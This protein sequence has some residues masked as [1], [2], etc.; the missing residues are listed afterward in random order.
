MRIAALLL[1][2]LLPL[3]LSANEVLFRFVQITDIHIGWEKDRGF[4]RSIP[5]QVNA[6]TGIEFVVLTGDIFD[7]PLDKADQSLIDEYKKFASAFKV[8]FYAIPGNHDISRGKKAAPEAARRFQELTGQLSTYRD[9]KGWRM[10]F[11]CE[12]PLTKWCGSFDFYQPVDFLEKTLKESPGPSIIFLHV[13]P[14][15]RGKDGDWSPESLTLWSSLIHKYDVKG[16]IGGH[17]HRDLLD[18]DGKIPLMASAPSVD[19]GGLLAVFR[20][21]TVFKD[22]HISYTT[23]KISPPKNGE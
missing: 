21:Y 13:P 7:K 18:W 12:L 17:L 11:F 6:M 22:G 5:E 1:L 20:I 15:D 14:L 10:I 9:C 4:Y 23:V 16:V 3:L 8:P 19:K 2:F